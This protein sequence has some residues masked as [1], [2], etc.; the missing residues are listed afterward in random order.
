M[1]LY[2]DV[3][4]GFAESLAQTYTTTVATVTGV[5]AVTDME[6]AAPENDDNMSLHQNVDE[7]V[8]RAETILGAAEGSEELLLAEARQVHELVEAVVDV[9]D[10]EDV[11]DEDESENEDD[12]E[13][14]DDAN[15]V[16]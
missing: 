10:V 8:L 15:D 9:E 4:E 14:G 12:A 2:E 16:D 3:N 11:E 1:S 6:A 5:T 7:G 13:E